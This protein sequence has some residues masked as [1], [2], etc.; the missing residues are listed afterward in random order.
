MPDVAPLPFTWLD[1]DFL[2]SP[3]LWGSF[4]PAFQ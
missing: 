2:K 3:N 1:F 4:N